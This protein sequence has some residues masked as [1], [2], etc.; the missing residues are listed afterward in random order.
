MFRKGFTLIELLVVI[1]II[2][3]LAA[4]LF[5]VFAQARE[6]ARQT[7]CLS[8]MKQ[9]GTAH[10]LY[11]DDY[12][13][14]FVKA[15][16]SVGSY[17]DWATL[18]SAT[19][20]SASKHLYWNSAMGWYG[21]EN[22]MMNWADL[23]H[24]Y[25]KNWKMFECPSSKSTKLFVAGWG[26]TAPGTALSY[27]YNEI[28]GVASDGPLCGISETEIKNPSKLVCNVDFPFADACRINPYYGFWSQAQGA[29]QS[30][31]RHN[32]GVNCLYC[33]GHAKYSK[34]TDSN[35][36]TNWAGHSGWYNED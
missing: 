19:D 35:I 12:D 30:L 18:I 7:S 6:K 23:L 26:W 32:D 14:V 13:G 5:P 1:A 28:V 10:M 22:P 25:C 16:S 3:I 15:N 8:N 27:G 24:P 36:F 34:K 2:A 11:K 31:I 20:D 4:I 21:P 9:I 33:D 17:N 29:N